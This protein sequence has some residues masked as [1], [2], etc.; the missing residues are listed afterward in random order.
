MSV[1]QLQLYLRTLHRLDIVQPTQ[2]KY[3]SLSRFGP[4]TYL[5]ELFVDTWDDAARCKEHGFKQF[6]LQSIV[7]NSLKKIV[8]RGNYSDQDLEPLTLHKR[9]QVLVLKSNEVFTGKASTD[10]KHIKVQTLTLSH[11][12]VLAAFNVTHLHKVVLARNNEIN[13]SALVQFVQR[14]PPTIDKVVFGYEEQR[15]HIVSALHAAGI[16]VLLS[17]PFEFA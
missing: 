2:R 1:P 15:A 9:V 3:Q 8:I 16:S 4:L 11:N 5:K 12:K 6:L 10:T 14:L 13:I 7:P 17:C